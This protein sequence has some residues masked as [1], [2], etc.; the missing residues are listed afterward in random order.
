MKQKLLILFLV[1][2]FGG[3]AFGQNRK[4]SGIVT[5]AADKQPLPSVTVL[6]KGT[7]NGTT[8]GGDGRYELTVSGQANTLVFSSVGY[9]RV[10]VPVTGSNTYDLAM[11]LDVLA[12]NEV[13]VTALGITRE[14]K[15]LGYAVQDVSGDVIKRSAETNVINSLAG[16]SAGVYVNSSNGNV[17][18]SSRIIIRGNQSLKGNNQPLFVVD[19]VP[20]D[21]SIVES[22]RGGYDFTDLGNGAAD[23]NPSDIENMTILKG[24]NAS[25]L[26]GSRGANGVILITTKSG[27]K[28][29]FNVEW[30]IQP[31]SAGR[32]YC[33]LSRMIT[34]KAEAASSGTKTG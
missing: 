24:G 28:K 12:I 15:A 8:T 32:W 34:D 2:L 26:Y 33:L 10:E 4:L 6:E 30:R 1:V 14:K 22:T 29:G 7:Q 16:R 20:I 23:I 27:S 5:S 25:A 17:G 11:E 9:R 21:N 13:V 19:G 18:A 31:H 3:T